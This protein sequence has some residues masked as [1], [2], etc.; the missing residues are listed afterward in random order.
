MAL[1]K[2]S[3]MDH[4]EVFK[5]INDAITQSSTEL[6]HVFG[7]GQPRWYGL[8]LS[9]IALALQDGEGIEFADVSVTLGGEDDDFTVDI[10]ILSTSLLI[11]VHGVRARERDERTTSV[12]DR[13]TLTAI[14]I[15]TG[16]SAFANG[17][18]E[19]WPGRVSLRLTYADDL[20][21]TL[22]QSRSANREQHGRVSALVPALRR[23]LTRG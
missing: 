8:A 23:D 4:R 7:Y 15:T 20:T 1:W 2:C 21:L 5:P 16:T 19:S 22:P 10:A 14:E 3:G 17:L 11:Q 13:A 9:D 6:A 12:R 18:A